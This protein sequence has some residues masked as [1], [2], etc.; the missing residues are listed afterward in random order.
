MVET[1]APAAPKKALD[2][3]AI[4]AGVLARNVLVARLLDGPAAGLTLLSPASIER[5]KQ[6]FN[7]G[8]K[9]PEPADLQATEILREASH[10]KRLDGAQREVAR[11][12]VE[13]LSPLAPVL[14]YEKP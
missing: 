10:S 13:T 5:F 9:L 6:D 8:A 4:D 12:W 2:P 11:R 1:S 14:G 3:A 7:S